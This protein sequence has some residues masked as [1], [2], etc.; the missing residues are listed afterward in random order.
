MSVRVR[1]APSPTGW[2]HVGGARTA[3]YNYLFARR[4]GGTFVLRIE[5]TDRE[6]STEE[7][8]EAIVSDLRWLGLEWDEGP[9]VGGAHGPYRQTERAEMY[10]RELERL[11]EAGHAYECFCTPEELEAERQAARAARTSFRYSRRCRDLSPEERERRRAVNPRPAIRFRMPESGE[12]VI[13]DAVRGRVRFDLSQLDDFVIARSDGTPTYNFAVVVDDATMGITHVIRGDDHLSNTPKQVA[14]FKALGYEVPSYAH[15]SM[16]HGPDRKPLSKRHGATAIFE[17]RAQGYVP[18]ALVNYLALLGWSL[19]DRTTVLS[20]DE[21][22]RNF[23][24]ERVSA[25]PAVFDVE[26]LTWL[27][28]VWIRSLSNDE[29]ARR[30]TPFVRERYG[31]RAASDPAVAHLLELTRER[32]VRLT[33]FADWTYFYFVDDEDF[34]VAEQDAPKLASE[35][36]RAVLE[37]ARA[38]LAAVDRWEAAA[39][40]A[41]L[42]GLV[43]ATGLKAK[44]VFQPIRIAT[45]GSSVSPPLFESLA[46]LGRGRTIARIERALG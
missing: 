23:S 11:L 29:L 1:F 2:L 22:V 40:E 27:N 33:E 17:F 7:A 43:E 35:E 21:L 36:A 16:I 34:E 10:R 25:N 8:I 32:M 6:R 41:A 5:D 20:M 18:E 45:T 39:I 28:G 3:L 24:L 38:A 4:H 31:D 13:D 12:V 37:R 19:D 15:L 26:K 42:R 14:L 46:L 9:G 30:V 44:A